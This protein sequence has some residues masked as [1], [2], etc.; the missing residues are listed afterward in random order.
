[1]YLSMIGEMSI[2]LQFFLT[3][4]TISAPLK[5]QANGQKNPLTRGGKIFLVWKKVF[6]YV[7]A[8]SPE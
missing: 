3:L 1:M 6:P 7:A 2:C 5:Y 4:S 8:K